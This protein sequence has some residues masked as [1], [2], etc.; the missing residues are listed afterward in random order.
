MKKGNAHSN[1][2]LYD[3]RAGLGYGQLEPKYHVPKTAHVEFPYITPDTHELEGEAIDGDDLD[4][5]VSK[6]NMGY[7]ITDFMSDRKNDPHYFVAGNDKLKETTMKNSISPIPNLY[8]GMDG[9]FGGTSAPGQTN[10]AIPLRTNQQTPTGSK[11]G[12]SRSLPDDLDHDPVYQL[13]D[14]PS[15][16]EKDKQNVTDL[17]KLISAIYQEQELAAGTADGR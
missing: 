5:F 12:W 4:A 14:F 15:Q 16:E 2:P 8:R 13:K 9:V 3:D 1:R 10:A 7:H 11:L 17:R 6:V